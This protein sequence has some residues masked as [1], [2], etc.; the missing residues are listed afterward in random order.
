MLGHL[1]SNFT[2]PRGHLCSGFLLAIGKFRT[3][4]QILIKR[5]QRW[6]QRV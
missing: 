1:E 5:V 4:V 6:I 3:A 2:Q